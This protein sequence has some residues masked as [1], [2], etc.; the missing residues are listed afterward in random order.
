MT[1]VLQP[2]CETVA[3][4]AAVGYRARCF[5]MP[6][7]MTPSRSAVAV[8]SQPGCDPPQ[9]LTAGYMTGHGADQFGLLAGGRQLAWVGAIGADPE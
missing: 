9:Y 1:S 7:A 5:V 2:I 3:S 8:R 4:A 6:E